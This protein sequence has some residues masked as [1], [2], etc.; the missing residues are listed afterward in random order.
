MTGISPTPA[1]ITCAFATG[2][3]LFAGCTAKAQP[4][5]DAQ[6]GFWS[7][8]QELCGEAYEGTVTAGN[9]SD[10]TFARERLVMHV[11]ECGNEEVRIPFHVGDDRSRT[12]IVSRTGD[13]LR[14]KHDHRHEDGSEDEI[15]QYGGDTVDGGSETKQDFHA[16]QHTAELIPAAAANVWTME[17]SDSVFAYALKREAE[18]RHFRAEFDLTQPVAPP[19]APWGYED[20]CLFSPTDEPGASELSPA[21]TLA[22]ECGFL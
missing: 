18:G 14:L 2:L 7:R 4:E 13:G 5:Q 1:R 3:L 19:P 9:E 16:D 11:R 22:G 20:D 12:W 8:L 6:E 15:T 17:V 10:S 21:D